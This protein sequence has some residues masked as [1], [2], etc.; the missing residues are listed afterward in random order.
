[1]LSLEE[2]LAIGIGRHVSYLI[3][4]AIYSSNGLRASFRTFSKPK[5]PRA[6]PHHDVAMLSLEEYACVLLLPVKLIEFKWSLHF[7]FQHWGE[8][9]FPQD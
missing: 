8:D 2:Y 7:F 4:P 3:T 6:I 9:N 1:M 5:I